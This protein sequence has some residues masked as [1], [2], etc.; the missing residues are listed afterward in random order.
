MEREEAPVRRIEAFSDGVFAIAITLLIL[1]IKIPKL[2]ASAGDREL[3]HA[4]GHLWP[5]FMAFLASFVAILIMW[6]NHHGLLSLARAAD[7]RLMFANGFLLFVVTFVPFPTAVL[8]EHV[9]GPAAGAAA[10]FYCSTYVLVSLAYIALYF[11]IAGNR[12]L[13]K[14]S[15]ADSTL[16]R[17]RNAYFVGFPIYAATTAMAFFYPLPAIGLNLSLWILWATLNY[18]RPDRREH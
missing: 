10:A 12:R 14:P 4:I 9:E 17:I 15:V 7:S 8:A 18:A 11:A 16:T 2:D 1:E 3:M 13:V 5:S 6:V